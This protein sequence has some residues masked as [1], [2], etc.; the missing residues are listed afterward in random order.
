MKDVQEKLEIDEVM[1]LQLSGMPVRD[2]MKCNLDRFEQLLESDSHLNGFL[3]KANSLLDRQE[4]LGIVSISCQ[5]ERYPSRL[6]AIGADAPALIHCLGNIDLLDEEKA[7]AIIG[8]RAADKEGNTKAYRLGKEYAEKGYVIVSGLALGCDTS[9]HIG[10]LDA[11]GKTIA[12][13]GNGLDLTHPKE[14]VILQQRILDNGGLLLSEQV[15]GVKANPTRLV[16]RNRLQAALS[17]AVILAQCPA[18]SGS[19][20]TMRFARQ[21]GKSSYA[22]TFPRRTPANAGNYYLLEN[23]LAQPL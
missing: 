15:I 18:Q 10:C 2:I 20:H 19:L 5:D 11:G 16:A 21:Y 8:A 17:E 14:N 3:D 23:N 4:A 12:I 22:A 6:H 7:V 9:A 1:A 13:V